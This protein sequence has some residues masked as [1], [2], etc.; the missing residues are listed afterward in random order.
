MLEA[1]IDEHLGYEKNSILGNNCG[2][3]RNGYGKKHSKPNLES[4]KFQ[5]LGTETAS[6]ICYS[7]F[8]G[9]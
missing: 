7:A 5:Y 3:S 9:S 4:Q 8:N 1:G 6:Y 2:N